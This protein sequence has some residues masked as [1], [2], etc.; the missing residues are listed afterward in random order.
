M[1]GGCAKRPE[2]GLTIPTATPAADDESFQVDAVVAVGLF[3]V[4]L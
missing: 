4:A 2:F 3:K 1:S